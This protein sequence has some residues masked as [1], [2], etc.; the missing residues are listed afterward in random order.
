MGSGHAHSFFVHAHS[1]L[2]RLPPECKLLA[3]L[4]FV[5]AVV[6]TPREAFW[7][8]GLY[9]L[10]ILALT[11]VARVPVGF[12]LK[13]LVIEVPFL[14]FAVMMPFLGQGE[15][16]AVLGLS[17]STEGLWAAWN[18]VAK[19]T[20]GLG[21]SIV[22]GAT[23]QIPEILVGMEKLR[24]PKAFTSIAGFMIRYLEV[25]VS[26]MQRMKVARESRCYNPRWFWQARAVATSAGALFIRSYERGERV[27]LA[28]ISRGYDGI[29]PTLGTRAASRSEWVA[30]LALPAGAALVAAFAWARPL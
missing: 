9:A 7:A 25:I 14:A 11:R 5:L 18:I 30:C 26:D 8:F 4:L 23:T 13:R 29:M 17:L 28:M 24:A 27:Y 20:L 21:A 22:L 3:S 1:P 19:G 16:V 10:A 15:R 6:F 12:L 2:H